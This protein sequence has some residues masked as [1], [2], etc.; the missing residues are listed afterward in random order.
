[1]DGLEA[2]CKAIVDIV[3]SRLD[4]SLYDIPWRNISAGVNKAEKKL[5]IGVFAEDPSYPIHPPQ[6]RALKEATDRLASQGHT[7]VPLTAAECRLADCTEVAYDLLGVETATPNS[8]LYSSGEPVIPSYKMGLKLPD[9]GKRKFV[10]DTS[11]MDGLHRWCHG[12]VLKEQLQEH[13]TALWLS[14]RLDIALAPG[15][16]STAVPHDTFRQFAYTAIFNLLDV[17]RPLHGFRIAD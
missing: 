6:K 14:K 1:M 10:P 17:S 5:T 15:S 2:Y 9:R 3:P 11:N 12:N 16:Q 13:W 7:I 8:Y 4:V